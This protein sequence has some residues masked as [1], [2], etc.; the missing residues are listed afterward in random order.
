VLVAVWVALGVGVGAV[1]GATALVVARALGAWRSLRA[2]ARGARAALGE[3]ETRA[4]A[5]ERKAAGLTEKSAAATASVA[6]LEESL[7]T[8]AVL[9]AAAGE[10][11]AA[12]RRVRALAP[13]K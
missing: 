5:S 8:F 3:L 6:R 7:A 12:V 2:F 4:L 11:G 10:T 9:R 13:R 1:A